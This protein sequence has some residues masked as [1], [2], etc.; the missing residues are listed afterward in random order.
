MCESNVYIE[1][2]G[3]EILIFKDVDF[4]QPMGDQIILRDILGEE[5]LLKNRIKFISFS[6]HKIILE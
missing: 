3:K 6:D 5:K 2:E 4:I 1:K